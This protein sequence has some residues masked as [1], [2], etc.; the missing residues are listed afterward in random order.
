MFLNKC[1]KRGP[2]IVGLL[3]FAVV[4]VV[5]AQVA[6]PQ[7]DQLSVFE[8]NI[9][10]GKLNETEKPLLQFVLSNPQN[11]RGLELVGRLRFRQGRLDEALAL[12]KRVLVLDPRFSAAKVTYATVLFAAG[13]AETARTILNEIDERELADPTVL[14]D[15]A[16]ALTLG[17]A[18]QRSLTVVE[19]L[20]VNIQI[21]DALPI[22]AV[23]HIQLGDIAAFEA[24][25]PQAKRLV[26]AKPVAAVKFV[27][28]L[29][30]TGRRRE[31]VALLRSLAAAFPQNARVLVMLA[32]TAIAD[33]DF[34]Q[35]RLHLTRAVALD[36][37]LAEV[38]STRAGLE[39]AE[40]SP[41][42]ALQSLEKALTLAPNSTEILSQMVIAAMRAN[43]TRKAV[44]A[45]EKLIKSDPDNA[46]YLY[47]HGT[48]S[49][50]NG[51][52]SNAKA[53]LERFAAARPNDS[54]GCVA[55]GLTLTA[56]KAY[57]AARAQFGRCLEIDASNF[58]AKYQLGLLSKAQGDTAAAIQM[59]EEVI[60]AR[61][62]DPLALR[63]L[64]TLYLQIGMEAK[65]RNALER[66]IALDPNDA[67]THFQ[68]SRL[69]NMIGEPGL[70][71]KHLEQFQKLKGS[72][73]ISTN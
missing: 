21:G 27:E 6:A 45:A 14:L 23:C 46:D 66:S 60:A 65:A 24:L 62:N 68:L 1:S 42:L 53:S 25:I 32:K 38:W 36:P 2:L 16:R 30:S 58:E 17:G 3:Y 44:D 39:A 50:Q 31:A 72:G 5:F 59:L 55:L 52:L 26:P 10:A 61:P 54:R 8:K 18:Y 56:Q 4:P 49:L 41:Q 29:V 19:R 63:E 12:Y 57:D 64:G 67:G 28:I 73:G 22:R 40:G 7:R 71:R 20:P 37:R 34:S 47:L 51:S 15:L 69:Y 48:A 13:Q 70:A 35:A 9:E 43:Q 11:A 33:N